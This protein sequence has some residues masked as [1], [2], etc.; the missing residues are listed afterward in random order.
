MTFAQQGASRMALRV[1]TSHVCW[2]PLTPSGAAV[3]SQKELGKHVV[4]PTGSLTDSFEGQH[5]PCLLEALDAFDQP[6]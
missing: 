5:Q 6:F 1:H 4:C 2:R 3:S